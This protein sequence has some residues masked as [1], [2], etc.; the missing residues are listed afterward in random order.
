MKAK[1]TRRQIFVFTPQE[2]KAA[3]CVV[4]ALLLGFAT[5]EYREAHPRKPPPPSAR[6]QYQQQRAKKAAAAYARSARAKPEANA[7]RPTFSP[8]TEED[9]EEE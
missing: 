7:Q 6:E 4:G 1:R 5:R 2:K 9:G 3:A 8:S